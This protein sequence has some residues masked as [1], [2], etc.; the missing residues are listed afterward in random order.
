[1]QIQQCRVCHSTDLAL[2]LD[3][4]ET[5][6]ANRFLKLEQLHEPEPRHPLRLVVC[7]QCGLVQIDEDV[8]REDIFKD[9][10]Y[11]SGTSDLMHKHAHRLAAG[12]GDQYALQGQDLVLEPA[13]NDGTVL[14]AFQRRGHRVLGVEPAANI[15]AMA[16]KDGIETLVEFFDGKVG[17]RVRQEHGPAKLVLARHVLAHV[18]DLHGFVE[19]IRESLAYDGVGVIECP[20][21]AE[22]HHK[23]EFDTIYHEHLCYWS[24]TTLRKLFEMH[25]MKAIDV[26]QVPLHGGSLLFHVAH[27]TAPYQPSLRL[28]ALLVKEAALELGAVATWESFARRVAQLRQDLLLF[29]D[30]A[31]HVGQVIVGY[32]APAKAT[33]LL[34]YCGMGVRHLPYIVDKSPHKQG[35]YTPG[36][37][38]PVHDPARL[39]EDQPDCVLILAWNFAE[40]VMR[41]QQAFWRRGGRFAVPIP[42]PQLVSVALAA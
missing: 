15:A 8:P 26:E 23:L 31:A 42:A 41:Q 4:G 39:L 38:I 37:H 32:G 1:M 13:S 29:F 40:E 19:G 12:L 2:V 27:A 21:V 35:K 28:R 10:V 11:V 6:L 9:Y 3:L 25:G 33:T 14:K 36:T 34:S 30:D 7:E 18:T 20:Y 24:L 5:A 17:K 22:L 16:Q